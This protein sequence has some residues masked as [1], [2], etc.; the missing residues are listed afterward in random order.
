MKQFVVTTMV[1]CGMWIGLAQGDPVLGPY[2]C[3]GQEEGCELV[4]VG[5]WMG[6]QGHKYRVTCPLRDMGMDT[7]DLGKCLQSAKKILHEGWSITLP[8]PTLLL[9]K[10]EVVHHATPSGAM[11]QLVNSV[12]CQWMRNIEE[13]KST[14]G[15][16]VITEKHFLF[17]EYFEG[18]HAE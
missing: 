1:V 10:G 17:R 8:A 12:A 16:L 14:L 18:A 9:P 15:G 13:F 7:Q 5:K 11:L 6:F 2:Q 3:A 4:M